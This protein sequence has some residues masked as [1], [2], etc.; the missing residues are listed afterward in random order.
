MSHPS[1]HETRRAARSSGKPQS[2]RRNHG[3]HEIRHRAG[4]I[5]RPPDETPLPSSRKQPLLDTS[6]PGASAQIGSALRAD[7]HAFPAREAD[8]RSAADLAPALAGA[9]PFTE[10]PV[11]SRVP[12][13]LGRIVGPRPPAQWSS[14]PVTD[15][16]AALGIPTRGR[17]ILRCPSCGAAQRGRQDRRGPIGLTLNRRGW[18]CFA[19][20]A[21]GDGR[22]FVAYALGGE[23]LRDLVRADL[24]RVT[25][26][27]AEQGSSDT[28]QSVPITTTSET[29]S[30]PGAGPPP[31]ADVEALWAGWVSAW[32][33]TSSW[34]R[35]GTRAS[36]SSAGPARSRSG[37]PPD[38]RCT[39]TAR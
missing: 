30:P 20:G 4:R 22:D 24:D 6:K 16:A 21:G 39:R 23:R 1:R 17:A 11:R 37:H 26:W 13:R 36:P 14:P 32:S 2:V 7:P 29:P 28:N 12:A 34:P 19:C 38:R 9:D 25:Q 5:E 27:L 10:E 8:D 33:I 15:A 18:R 35:K 3:W 31:L